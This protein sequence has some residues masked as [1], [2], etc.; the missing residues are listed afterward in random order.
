[1]STSG[2]SRRGFLKGVAAAAGAL[3]ATRLMGGRL[4]APA[5]AADPVEAPAA[6]LFY[7][8]GGYNALFCS[9]D[10]F[11]GNGAFGVRDG[12]VLRV[13]QSGLYVDRNSLGTLSASTLAHMASIGVKHGISQ[14]PAAQA[15]L[16]MKG[17]RSRPIMLSAAL[18]G[19][20]ALRCV[21]V[22]ANEPPGNH[23]AEGGVSMQYVRDLSTTIAALGGT[24]KAG[25]PRRELAAS[26]LAVSE[27]M[28]AGRLTPNPTS[29]A[30]LIEGYP[31][32]VAMLSDQAQSFDYAE[33]ATAYGVKPNANGEYPT[34]VKGVRMHF[35]AAE[36]M[37][38]AGANVVIIE[39][40]GWDTHKD[41]N[42]SQVR[43]MM[44]GRRIPQMLKVFTDRTLAM[45]NRNVVTTLFG[46]FSRSLPGSDHQANLTATVIGKYVKLGT[47]GRV[48]AR[49]GLPAGT[50]GIEGYWAYLA[51]A[52]KCPEKPFGNNPHGL[53]L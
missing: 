49:V 31:A 2:L 32:A 35:V 12:N 5:Y 37:I 15:N 47:T 53:V 34:V 30:S 43:N 16:W 45:Q 11:L 4:V 3:G 8:R 33:I 17:K 28:S 41:R 48:N 18:G 36:I 42:G 24:T 51:A 10:S 46:D 19:D 29:G 21:T 44:Q 7:M 23:R 50:P 39:N 1:M 27:A 38:R 22:G 13:K 14:H 26:G 40:R 6:L 9:A 25:A 52:L 20:A